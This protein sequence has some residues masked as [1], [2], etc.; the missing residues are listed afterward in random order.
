MQWFI[1]KTETAPT[2][3]YGISIRNKEDWI[4]EYG[5]EALVKMSQSFENK[6]LPSLHWVFIYT[7]DE[8]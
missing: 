8:D 1:K 2:K 4:Q 5:Q 6:G 7:I 3:P